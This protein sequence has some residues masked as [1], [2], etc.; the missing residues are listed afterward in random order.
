VVYLVLEDLAR[1][2]PASIF[3]SF[4][5][6]VTPATTMREGRIYVGREVRQGEASLLVGLGSADISLNLRIDERKGLGRLPPWCRS[7]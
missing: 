1:S 6:G 7:R 2:P 3:T 5:S 4:W